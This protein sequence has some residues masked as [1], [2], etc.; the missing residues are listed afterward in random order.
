MLEKLNKIRRTIFSRVRLSEF[1]SMETTGLL[2]STGP[3]PI[4]LFLQAFFV[5]GVLFC[6]VGYFIGCGLVQRE[7]FSEKKYWAYQVT[8]RW[9]LEWYG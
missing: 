5:T 4:W 8:T 2:L 6:G 1:I 7:F 3:F 9:E